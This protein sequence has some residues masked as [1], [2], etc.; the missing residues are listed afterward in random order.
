MSK[1]TGEILAAYCFIH[2]TT[3]DMTPHG[4]HITPKAGYCWPFAVDSTLLAVGCWLLAGYCN[5][6]DIETDRGTC[7]AAHGA[8]KVF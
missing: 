2:M 8:V 4:H 7:A 5:F 1:G 6:S 3:Q